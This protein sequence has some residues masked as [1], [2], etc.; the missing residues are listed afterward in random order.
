VVART[1]AERY[2]AQRMDD[3]GYAEAYRHARARIG[4]IDELMASL[5]A[6]REAR[7]LSKAELARRAGLK[8]EAVRRLFSRTPAN[9]TLNTLFALADALSVEI[10]L[11]RQERRPT[12][13]RARSGAA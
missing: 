1:G 13:K 11:V 3:P 4:F 7:G 2:F 10:R 5:D 12:A 6:E 8:P 9:P